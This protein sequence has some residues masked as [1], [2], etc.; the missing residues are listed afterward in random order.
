MNHGGNVWQGASPGGWLDFSANLRPDGPPEWVYQAM[1]AAINDARYYPDVLMAEAK[2]GIARYAGVPEDCVLPTSGGI[3]AID[4]AVRGQTGRVLVSPPT[5]SEY[6]ALARAAGL[7]VSEDGFG[8]LKTGDT[9]FL[10]NPN[11]PTGRA[12]SRDTVL[13]IHARAFSVRARLIVDEA[14]IDCCPKHSVR[15][16]AAA[17]EGLIVVGSLTKALSVPGVRLGY[18]IARPEAVEEI[19]RQVPPWSLNAFA[20]LIAKRL[21]AHLP[22]LEADRVRN[23][24]RRAKFEASLAALGASVYPSEASFL[25]CD[26]EKPMDND[27]A[28]L[29]EE[30]ILV[31][32]CASFGLPG[33]IL[34]LAVKTEAQNARLIRAL[35]RIL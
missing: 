18:L 8:A 24:A 30:G 7:E 15:E 23:A 12:L 35:E 3:A 4:V 5:F 11:N 13:S 10:C 31:R 17:L 9:A 14:F 32:T 1:C 34:R 33:S 2:R 19:G 16:Q 26:F 25:L 29:K 20:A 22:E 21:P 6:A 28:I 27:V